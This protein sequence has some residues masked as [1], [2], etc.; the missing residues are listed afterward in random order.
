[1]T[2]N[3]K[4]WDWERK[5]QKKKF[6]KKITIKIMMTKFDVKIIWNQMLRNK[7]EKNN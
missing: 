2:Q 6:F 5:I 1:M 7:I 3:T 4:W